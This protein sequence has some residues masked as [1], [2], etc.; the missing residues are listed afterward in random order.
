MK[1]IKRRELIK[2][3]ERL[4]FSYESEGRHPIYKCIATGYRIPVPNGREIAPG[5]L[6]DIYKLL[7]N[8]K[9]LKNNKNSAKVI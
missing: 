2:V 6:R 7:N 3:L 1:A 4:G 8:Y 9:Q 5:T